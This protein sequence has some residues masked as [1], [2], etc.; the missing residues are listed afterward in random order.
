MIMKKGFFLT[1]FFFGLF[2]YHLSSPYSC[3]CV[4]LVFGRTEKGQNAA[5]D[6][7]ILPNSILE[8]SLSVSP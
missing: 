8:L 7:S 1:P 6:F 3:P 2:D 5:S 4:G